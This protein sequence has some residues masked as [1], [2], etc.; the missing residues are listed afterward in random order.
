MLV[1][2]AFVLVDIISTSVI[3]SKY[4]Y[5]HG[6]LSDFY[7]NRS[8]AS[9]NYMN[10]VYI[11]PWCRISPYAIGLVLGYVLYEL[12]QRSNTLSWESILPRRRSARFNRLNQIIAWI[13][14][15]LILSLCVFGTYGDYND[16]PLTRSGRITFLVLSRFGWSVGLSIVIITCFLGQGGI[17]NKLLSH[18]F[19]R[20]LSKLNYGAYLWHSLVIFVNYFGRDQPTHYTITNIVCL[21]FSLNVE[22]ISFFLVLEFYYS[23]NYFLYFILLYSSSYRI[24]NHS[25]IKNRV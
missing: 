5:D 16:R 18:S 17:V 13:F 20:L 21:I 25:I 8:N 3:V 15:L 1:A 4:N 6:V 11:K 24:T 2:T 10:D 19:F 14:A 23:Y 9:H 7:V 22:I 12:Y